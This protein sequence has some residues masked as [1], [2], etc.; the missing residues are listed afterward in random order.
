MT[1]ATLNIGIFF[2]YREKIYETYSWADVGQTPTL[3]SESES[4]PDI[5]NALGVLSLR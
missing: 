5:Q 4:P 3:V 1:L 2:H